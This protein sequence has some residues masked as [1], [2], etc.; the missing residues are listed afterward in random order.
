M[1]DKN[2]QSRNKQTQ[3]QSSQDNQGSIPKKQN[4][5]QKKGNNKNT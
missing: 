4:Q 5:N 2:D 1:S 3:M